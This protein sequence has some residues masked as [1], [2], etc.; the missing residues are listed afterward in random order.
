MK[1]EASDNWTF[2]FTELNFTVEKTRWV[3]RRVYG[4]T[5]QRRLYTEMLVGLYSFPFNVAL[6]RALIM[7]HIG[8]PTVS[9]EKMSNDKM[10]N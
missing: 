8:Y 1:L 2:M 6:I 5:N 7:V 10:S 4:T 3:Y 9:K